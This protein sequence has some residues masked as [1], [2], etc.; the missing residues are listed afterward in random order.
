MILILNSSACRALKIIRNDIKVGTISWDLTAENP[1]FNF[2][3]S[4]NV[5]GQLATNF[6]HESKDE[7]KTRPERIWIKLR[8]DSLL[9]LSF[10]NNL[11][12]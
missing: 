1:Y 7:I 10:M 11:R 6:L 2:C 5:G 12:S 3:V 9:L 4:E 8:F